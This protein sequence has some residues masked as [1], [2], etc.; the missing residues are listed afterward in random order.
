MV[1]PVGQGGGGGSTQW[2]AVPGQPGQVRLKTAVGNRIS[3]GSDDAIDESRPLIYGQQRWNDAGVAFVGMDLDITDDASDAGSLLVRMQVDG[4]P[5]FV[6]DKAGAVTASRAILSSTVTADAPLIQGAQTWNA[7]G[8]VFRGAILNITDTASAAGSLALDLQRGG[9]S[10]FAFLVKA[11]AEALRITNPAGAQVVTMGPRDPVWGASFI[12]PG[13]AGLFIGAAGVYEAIRPERAILTGGTMTADR[14][15][16]SGTQTWNN[17][18]VTFTLLDFE[19]TNTASVLGSLLLRFRVGA[20]TPFALDHRGALALKYGYIVVPTPGT[21]KF[22]MYENAFEVAS[23][24]PILWSAG[25]SVF[26][27]VDTGLVR[28]AAGALKITNGSSGFGSVAASAYYGSPDVLISATAA[29]L[30]SVT[31]VAGASGIIDLHTDGTA[32][33]RLGSAGQYVRSD[34]GIFWANGGTVTVGVDTAIRRAAAGRLVIF[35]GTTLTDFRDLSVRTVFGK[36]A[37]LAPAFSFDGDTTTGIGKIDYSDSNRFAFVTAGGAYVHWVGS[38][39]FGLASGIMLGWYAASPIGSSSVDVAL[40]RPGAGRLRITDGSTGHGS[41]QI[42]TGGWEFVTYN[43]PD[44]LSLYYQGNSGYPM[45]NFGNGFTGPPAGGGLAPSVILTNRWLRFRYH[46]ADDYDMEISWE[47]RASDHQTHNFKIVGCAAYASAATNLVGMNL[48]FVGGAGASGSAGA[49]HG[50]HVYLDGGEGFGTGLD[51][52]VIIGNTRG[53]L[54]FGTPQAI[55]AETVTDY[56]EVKDL[57]GNTI[58][59]AIVS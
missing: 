32:M 50:G 27:V 13:S 57:A 47:A 59:L 43:H 48:R 31:I 49:A 29:F 44:G 11:N 46:A 58:K 24:M 36:A 34:H 39:T 37:N 5:V 3:L 41:L 26:G 1:G 21:Y 52:D 20:D 4:V 42:G 7:G 23:D 17:G 51:G 30:A 56:V 9:S 8:V 14:P 38:T 15:I 53:M 54:R 2:E 40:V 55:V 6:V 10:V 45:I 33:W 25:V 18:A 22:A 12:S 28:S 35:D 19:V 16:I